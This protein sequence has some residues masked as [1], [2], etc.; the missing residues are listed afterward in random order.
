MGNV[1]ASK[2]VFLDESGVNIDMTRK[3]GRAIGKERVV[4]DAPMRKGK[5]ITILSSVRLDGTTVGIEFEG[6]LNGE[7]FLKYIKEYLAPKLHEG[8]MVVMDNLSSHKVAGVEEAIKAVKAKVL[9]L[10]PYSPDLNPIEEMW[11]KMKAYL[12]KKKA[13]ILE[14]LMEEIH[15][16][17]KTITAENCVGWFGHSGYNV[18]C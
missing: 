13:R 15:N 5:R 1:P 14:T 7:L 10:P 18:N 12:R 4:D 17:F 3:Y 9:Y 6:A 11:S 8:D 2:L 16:A